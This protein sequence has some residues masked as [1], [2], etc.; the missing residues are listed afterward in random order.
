L[1]PLEKTETLSQKYPTC[2]RAGG[3]VQVIEH[4]SSKHE[5]LSSKPVLPNKK[6]ERRKN[7]GA[8]P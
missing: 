1:R 4:L 6:K 2:K 3:M 8:A 5:A 7:S